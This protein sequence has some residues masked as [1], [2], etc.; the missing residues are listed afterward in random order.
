MKSTAARVAELEPTLD[1]LNAGAPVAAVCRAV[2]RFAVWRRARNSWGP[3]PNAIRWP[4]ISSQERWIPIT[5][6]PTMMIAIVCWT[7]GV[8]GSFKLVSPVISCAV[9]V[10]ARSPRITKS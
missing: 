5:K 10:R 2:G 7:A 4:P 3:S 8:A 9:N 6:Q 1:E